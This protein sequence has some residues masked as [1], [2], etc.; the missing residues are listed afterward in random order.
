MSVVAP[1]KNPLSSICQNFSL[2]CGLPEGNASQVF[3]SEDG[4]SENDILYVNDQSC[5]D[6]VDNIL[7]GGMTLYI[8]SEL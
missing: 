4:E 5:E 3:V 2:G 1:D 7:C 6:R 8:L